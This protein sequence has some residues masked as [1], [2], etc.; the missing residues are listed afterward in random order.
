MESFDQRGRGAA[1]ETIQESQRM[2]FQV[3]NAWERR[4]EE[5][6]LERGIVGIRG[7]KWVGVL[8]WFGVV[9]RKVE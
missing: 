9:I 7:R 5:Q 4:V 8:V 6:D 1:E 2:G 3:I